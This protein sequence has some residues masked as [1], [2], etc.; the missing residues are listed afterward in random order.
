M[1]AAW[2]V[3]WVV[4]RCAVAGGR[5]PPPASRSA[6]T[7]SRCAGRRACRCAR[8]ERHRG[9]GNCAVCAVRVGGVWHHGFGGG[10]RRACCAASR[11]SSRCS[12]RAGRGTA[13]GCKGA[14]CRT[15]ETG[16]VMSGGGGSGDIRESG[17]VNH[18]FQI[19]GRRSEAASVRATSHIHT[20]TE[21]ITHTPSFRSS[22][23]QRLSTRCA[24]PS[25][26]CRPQSLFV[27]NPIRPEQCLPPP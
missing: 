17:R 18:R 1:H 19:G 2:C 20:H 7:C 5:V 12:C 15:S 27:N 26:V 25:L 13:A 9:A 16:D 3:R 4:A 21:T 6:G 24:R 22:C 10:G 14:G 11:R 8:T 23:V